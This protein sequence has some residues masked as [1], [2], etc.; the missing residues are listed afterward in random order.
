MEITSEEKRCPA[1]EKIKLHS[2]FNK[3]KS[4][5]DGLRNYC[6]DCEKEQYLEKK[7]KKEMGE[8]ENGIVDILDSTPKEIKEIKEETKEI[9]KDRTNVDELAKTIVKQYDQDISKA[10]EVFE[11]FMEKIIHGD[12]TEA[13][14]EALTKSLELR[15]SASESIARL[16]Q[17]AA[18][19]QE[20]REKNKNKDGEGINTDNI[21]NFYNIEE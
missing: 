14:K 10:D 12:N 2:E 4:K 17:I 16:I 18:K 1:C 13:S 11:L 3:D 8:L 6:K 9:T 5:K 7:R 20:A 19:L 15:M 21:K